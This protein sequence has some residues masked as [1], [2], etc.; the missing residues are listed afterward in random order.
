[1]PETVLVTRIANRAY[2]LKFQDKISN[3]ESQSRVHLNLHQVGYRKF[4]TASLATY[5]K[6]ME[7]MKMGRGFEIDEVDEIPT[8]QFE[9]IV[10]DTDGSVV[11][12]VDDDN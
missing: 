10:I 1:M 2:E 3:R 7:E 9:D 12:S 6:K 11:F 8:A 5:N 4:E